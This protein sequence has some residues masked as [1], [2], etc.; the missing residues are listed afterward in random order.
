M[1]ILLW[2][3]GE[4]VCTR[5]RDTLSYQVETWLPTLTSFGDCG[6]WGSGRVLDGCGVV[7]G[8]F[9]S[10]TVDRL[11]CVSQNCCLS[12]YQD[13]CK[14]RFLHKIWGVEVRKDPLCVSLLWLHFLWPLCRWRQLPHRLPFSIKMDAT[15]QLPFKIQST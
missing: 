10:V 5:S 15:L 4:H 3:K 14:E 8:V 12:I 7:C 6:L 2:G 1:Y 11:S 9:L 13:G